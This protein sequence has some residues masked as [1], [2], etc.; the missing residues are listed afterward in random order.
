MISS[1]IGETSTLEG[2]SAEQDAAAPIVGHE[3]GDLQ[4]R[5]FSRSA[6]CARAAEGT[7]EV[8][9][10]A[11]GGASPGHR[12]ASPLLTHCLGENDDPDCISS[13]NAGQLCLLSPLRNSFDS[14]ALPAAD[15]SATAADSRTGSVSV[16]P[17]PA[18]SAPR[19]PLNGQRSLAPLQQD[20]CMVS[21][22]P[23]GEVG[24]S[25]TVVMGALTPKVLGGS[26]S[27]NVAETPGA[28]LRLP[29][30][31]APSFCP[32]FQTPAGEASV[33]LGPKLTGALPV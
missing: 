8:S 9:S 21:P 17:E 22:R 13:A 26:A 1:E 10:R 24:E 16:G 15:S 5:A 23:G 4:G 7:A 6:P 28:R 3:D 27:V 32:P 33:N 29:S 31:V 30:G 14:P 11:F 2:A 20:S 19:A 25:D 12:S 18:S